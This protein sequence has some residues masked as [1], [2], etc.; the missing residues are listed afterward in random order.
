MRQDRPDDALQV[1]A[2]GKAVQPDTVGDARRGAQHVRSHRGELDRRG[3]ETTPRRRE[4]RG[5]QREIVEWAAVVELFAMFPA[6]EDGA[7]RRD[8]IRHARGGGDPRRAEAAFVVRL[9]LA[10]EA[11]GEAAVGRAVQVPG[12]VR[13][14]HRAAGEGDHHRGGEFDALGGEGG[15]CQRH[16]GI[17]AELVGLEGIEAVLFGGAGKGAAVCPLGDGQDG[18]HFHVSVIGG[19]GPDRWRRAAW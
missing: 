18:G 4:L 13:H 12:L 16:E 15:E 5:H 9:D 7:Q 3:A 1:G 2:G 14:H 19:R 10:A 11:E 17:V 8:I 6:G